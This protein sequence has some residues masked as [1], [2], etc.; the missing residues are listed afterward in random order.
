[1]K[2]DK[3]SLWI[4]CTWI[5]SFLTITTALEPAVNSRRPIWNIAHMVNSLAE[6][7]VYLNKGANA[8]EFDVQFNSDGEALY[9]HHGFPCDFFRK[10]WMWENIDAYL[11][12]MRN[13][14]TPGH[15][16]F[17]K[18]LV[19]LFLDLKV[20]KLTPLSLKHAS[21]SL[22]N[23]LKD[24]YWKRGKS[25][26]QAY[27]M[28]A[29]PSLKQIEFIGNFMRTLQEDDASF[30]SD[31]IGFTFFGNEDIETISSVLHH[32]QVSHRI[33][34]GDGITNWLPRCYRRLKKLLKMR[35]EE[36]IQHFSKVYW[37]TVDKMTT[38]RDILSL[39]VDAITTNY[40]DELSALIK[41]FPKYIRLA[42]INDNPWEKHP[43]KGIIPI[44]SSSSRLMDKFWQSE[45]L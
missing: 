40:P 34:Q 1:M 3:R 44:K 22:A 8:L 37:W 5:V 23:K 36:K 19:L 7:D 43:G 25:G 27:L 39:G 32:S 14:T 33:W 30:C 26:A 9:T 31:K 11:D 28:I 13:L 12:K 10:W 17:R 29:L 15:E 24:I 2:F 16:E 41:E 6:V 42:D 4:Q 18:E 35:N 45:E 38:M 20:G 21:K